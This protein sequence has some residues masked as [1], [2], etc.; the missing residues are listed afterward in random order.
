MQVIFEPLNNASFAPSI[1]METEVQHNPFAPPPPPPPMGCP[2]PGIIPCPP[3][4]I[5]GG[6]IHPPP[7]PPGGFEI[8]NSK[9]FTLMRHQFIY[10][11]TNHCFREVIGPQTLAEEYYPL[12]TPFVRGYSLKT[13]NW[14]KNP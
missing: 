1:P 14:G 3:P 8:P 11:L 5:H 7:P 12:C 10:A 9:L 4:P 13:K 2:P 6:Y